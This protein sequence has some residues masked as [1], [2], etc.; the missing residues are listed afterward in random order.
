MRLTRVFQL[1]E[2]AESIHRVD[3]KWL[4]ENCAHSMSDDEDCEESPSE[5][6]SM[7]VEFVAKVG[8]YACE[9]HVEYDD[10][11]NVYYFEG[12]LREVRK[13]LKDQLSLLEVVEG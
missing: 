6:F 12:T 11:N 4:L 3:V 2:L 1:D 9:I 10:F 7:G 5:I 13:T 8:D